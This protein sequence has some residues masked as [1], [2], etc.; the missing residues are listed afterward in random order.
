MCHGSAST[1]RALT[2][3]RP[4]A[5]T[6]RYFSGLMAAALF[7]RFSTEPRIKH[8]VLMNKKRRGCHEL[9]RSR[10]LVLVEGRSFSA[11]LRDCRAHLGRGNMKSLASSAENMQLR[12]LPT[13]LLQMFRIWFGSMGIG[14][15]RF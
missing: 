8:Y 1:I 7:Y 4:R 2:H 9:S 6:W 3:L 5:S 12:I 11:Q 13:T 15:L 10:T 14:R